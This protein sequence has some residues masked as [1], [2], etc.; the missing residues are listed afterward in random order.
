QIKFA[1]PGEL[2]SRMFQGRLSEPVVSNETRLRDGKF[3]VPVR[4]GVVDPLRRINRIKVDYWTGNPQANLLQ[5]SAVEPPLGPRCSPRRS[6]PLTLRADRGDGDAELVL[7]ALP[8][9]GKK[10]W[11]QAVVSTAIGGTV[12]M[13]GYAYQ[14][15]PPVDA[16]PM[17]LVLKYRE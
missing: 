12:W 13:P 8:P 1:I 11:V 6:V 7:D 10:L 3:V 4:I 14:V 2:V 16:K 9:S 17:S 5:P 15:Q